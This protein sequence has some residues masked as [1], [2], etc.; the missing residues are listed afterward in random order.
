M[1]REPGPLSTM[2]IGSLWDPP[3]ER[4]PSVLDGLIVTPPTEE[5]LARIDRAERGEEE[6]E[7]KMEPNEK[8]TLVCIRA[9]TMQMGDGEVAVGD[10]LS[11]DYNSSLRLL[12]WIGMKTA[13]KCFVPWLA[14]QTD[15]LAEDW[16]EV[17]S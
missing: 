9:G 11:G 17:A 5:L 7:P 15:L 10:W 13:D 2:E 16:M 4:G 3:R 8:P 6:M 12:P 1:T 14:S